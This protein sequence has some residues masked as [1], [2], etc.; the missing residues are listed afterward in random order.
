LGKGIPDVELKVVNE[1][2]QVVKP[3]E[4]GEIIAR[5]ENIMAGYFKDPETTAAT[6]RGGWLY[7]GDMATIDDE[8]YIFMQSR[9]K[10]IIKVRGVRVSPKEIEAVIVTFPGVID[11]TISAEHDDVTEE[12]LKATVYV[13]EADL[14]SFTEEKIRKHCAQNLSAI[15]V[16]QKVIFDTRL[17]FN[18]AGKK[19]KY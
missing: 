8:G 17:T 14:A 19:S 3:G 11:C 15:K 18:A 13:N 16:P 2:G 9:A 12:S 10:E 7:T 6:I 4:T 5:G 1:T